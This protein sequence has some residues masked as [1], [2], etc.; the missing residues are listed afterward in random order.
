MS[1]ILCTIDNIKILCMIYTEKDAHACDPQCSGIRLRLQ[2]YYLSSSRFRIIS[3]LK[4]PKYK[5]S[6][7]PVLTSCKLPVI[8]TVYVTVFNGELKFCF[9]LGLKNNP[10]WWSNL[11]FNSPLEVPPKLHIFNPF[12]KILNRQ[13]TGK[14]ALRNEYLRE[15]SNWDLLRPRRTI[16]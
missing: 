7:L 2:L 6:T 10:D 12:I 15:E 14:P 8:V 9:D 3:Y 1:N 16:N 13:K 5:N 11:Y 4:V